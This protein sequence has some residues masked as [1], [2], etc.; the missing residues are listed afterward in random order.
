MSDLPIKKY[1]YEKA[2][3]MLDFLKRIR[4]FAESDSTVSSYKFIPQLNGYRV[5]LTK[6]KKSIVFL[7][8]LKGKIKI[9][10]NVNVFVNDVSEYAYSSESVSENEKIASEILSEI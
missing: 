7:L 9:K 8:D 6:E 1:D 3:L 4:E 2:V 5:E 10:L